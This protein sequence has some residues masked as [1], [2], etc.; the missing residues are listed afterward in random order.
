[1]EEDI[2]NARGA[3]EVV[4]ENNIQIKFRDKDFY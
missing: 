3:D 2:L 4:V 1:M